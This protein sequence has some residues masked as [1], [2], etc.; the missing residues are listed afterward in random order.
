MKAHAR[1]VGPPSRAFPS[2]VTDAARTT[3][4]VD[5]AGDRIVAVDLATGEVRWRQADAGRPLVATGAGLL[6]VR[7]R[8]RRL[9]LALLDPATGDVTRELGPLGVPAWAA[10]EWDHSDGFAALAVPN[11]RTPKVAWRAVRRYRGGAAPPPER[12]ADAGDEAVGVIQVDVD[13]GTQQALP[14]GERAA[15]EDAAPSA[16]SPES[17]VSPDEPAYSIAATPSSDGTTAVTLTASRVGDEHPVWETVLDTPV[18]RRPPPL[19]P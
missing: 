1:S 19:R 6:V 3:A 17:A 2:G 14:D 12:L 16:E 10:D 18:T 5:L 4:F 13:S 7:R 8:H 11:G 9:E 15:I